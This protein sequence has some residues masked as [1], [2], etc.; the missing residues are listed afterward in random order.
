MSEITT[1]RWDDSADPQDGT[2][3]LVTRYRPRGLAKQLETWSEWYPDLGP[4]RELHAGAYGKGGM[5]IHWDTYRASYLREMRSQS[6]AIKALAERVL[7]GERI[8]LL[9]SSQCVRE[10][11]CHRS[12]LKGLI[13]TEIARLHESGQPA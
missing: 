13:E 2:R 12:L 7:G 8:T 9:C 3:I 11:R 10:S 5:Q 4:S 6:A 1:K